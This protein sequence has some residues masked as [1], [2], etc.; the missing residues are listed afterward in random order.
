MKNIDYI[1][2]ESKLVYLMKI[3]NFIFPIFQQ[4]CEVVHDG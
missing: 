2:T 4:Q 3:Y 1:L